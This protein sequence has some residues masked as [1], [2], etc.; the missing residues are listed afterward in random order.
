MVAFD[1]P[2]TQD[3]EGEEKRVDEEELLLNAASH[4]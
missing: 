1:A 2:L 3:E 4:S